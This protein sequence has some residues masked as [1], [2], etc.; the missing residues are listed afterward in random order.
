MPYNQPCR[1][2][3]RQQPPCRKLP[4][5][6]RLQKLLITSAGRARRCRTRSA[7][8]ASAS[9]VRGPRSASARRSTCV[10]SM[11]PCWR[12]VR[13][14]WASCRSRWTRGS[15][16]ASLRDLAP[17]E[18]RAHSLPDAS[19]YRRR[20]P[21]LVAA[22]AAHAQASAPAG[23]RA[24]ARRPRC[25]RAADIDPR[26]ARRAP[27]A[28]ADPNNVLA[29][30]LPSGV[31][32]IELAQRFAPRHADNIRTLV[33]QH[34]FDGLAVLRVQDNFVAQWGDPAA[35]DDDADQG[36]LV[37]RR[38]AHARAGILDQRQGPEHRPAEGS[39]RLGAGHRLRRRLPG[40]RR[41]EDAPR[42][43]RAL[44]R[45]GRRG[46]RQHGRQR[47]RRRALRRDR[48]IAARTRP[49]H[50][51]GGARAARHGTAVVPAARRPEHGLLRQ[52]RAEPAHH[53]DRAPGRHAGGH[54]PGR[55]GVSHRHA[56]VE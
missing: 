35:D 44:L 22:V 51:R 33:A 42:L 27:G 38:L 23:A 9:C 20:R 8:S 56:A 54:A 24:A 15:R 47:Q 11:T 37:R 29:M 7:R 55:A 32:W 30:T 10:H 45:H 17:K 31:V 18:S 2:R 34:Y 13:Y 48:P 40:R 49:Q 43:G 39:R 46:S 53:E 16:A 25:A 6:W 14:P 36:P 12:W 1:R 41:S 3:L 5:G 21:D 4:A 19:P 50:R 26:G 28:G 52:A